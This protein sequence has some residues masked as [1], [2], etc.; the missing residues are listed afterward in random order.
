MLIARLSRGVA[1]VAVVLALV[2]LVLTMTM[3]LGQD[4]GSQSGANQPPADKGEDLAPAMSDAQVFLYERIQHLENA[5]WALTGKVEELEYMLES[6]SNQQINSYRD[7]DRRI[8]ALGQPGSHISDTEAE[9]PDGDS[10]EEL[11]RRAF[12]LLEKQAFVESLAAFENLSE[13]YPNGKYVAESWYWQGELSLK[14]DPA[15]L[16]AARQKFVQL[17]TWYPNDRRAP[18]AMFKL[19]AVYEQL[20]DSETAKEYLSRVVDEYP[21]STVAKLAEEY[22]KELE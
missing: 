17:I 8:L 14:S 3:V 6:L 5:L 20:G 12:G 11:Y 16:E 15:N 9:L 13:K 4:S 22:Y 19:G 18:E 21:N 7:L 1:P 10:E 2:L